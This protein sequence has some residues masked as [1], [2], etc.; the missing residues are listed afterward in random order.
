LRP[1]RP[2]SPAPGPRTPSAAPRTPVPRPPT[3]AS[4]RSPVPRPPTP[5]S[6]RPPVP[7]PPTP[8]LQWLA[9]LALLPLFL[10]ACAYY[11][12]TGATIPEHLRTVAVPL[13]EDQ[14]TS[15]LSNLGD[16]LTRLFVDRFV[17]QTR[18]SLEPSSTE[19][20][21]VLTAEIQ[22]YMNQ[23]AAVGGEAVAT[24]N[25]ITITVLVTYHDQV[26]EQ[27]IFQRSFTASDEY[28]PTAEGLAG[29]ETAAAS[30]LE[31]IADD[32]FTAATSNW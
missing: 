27:Q 25:R 6:L 20:D 28:N 7:R 15:S 23:P 13:V 5:A 12:F 29:E 32:V 17:G 30:A 4:Q 3:P 2:P 24:L 1:P 19:A 16:E 8:A 26:N 9:V 10:G 18:L 31:N 11:S 14:S 22:R 21:A